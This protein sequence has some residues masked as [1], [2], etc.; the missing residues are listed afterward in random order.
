MPDDVKDARRLKLTVV[1]MQRHVAALDRLAVT[2]RLR[3][4]I[5]LSRASIID[6]FIAAS[7]QKPRDMEEKILQRRVSLSKDRTRERQREEKNEPSPTL[8]K[9]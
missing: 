7:M 4:G 5:A 3:T 6:A 9:S 8:T 2:I 1:L